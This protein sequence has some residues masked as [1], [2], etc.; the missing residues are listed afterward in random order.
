M[1]SNVIVLLDTVVQLVTQ[2]C[3]HVIQALAVSMVRVVILITVLVI[4]VVASQ[5]ILAPTVN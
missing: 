4:V 5:V 1:D 3:Q 2:G